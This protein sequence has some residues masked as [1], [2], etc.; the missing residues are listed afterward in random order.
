MELV[1]GHGVDPFRVNS[2]SQLSNET[3]IKI[4][5]IEIDLRTVGTISHSTTLLRLFSA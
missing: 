5:A 1:K 2:L 4:V 3:P